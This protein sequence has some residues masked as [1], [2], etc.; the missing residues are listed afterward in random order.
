M[1]LIRII[2]IAAAAALGLAA[3]TAMAQG[4]YGSLSHFSWEV[5]QSNAPAIE[6]SGIRAVG[7][8]MFSDIFG[9]EGHV[10]SGGDDEIELGGEE[11]EAELNKVLGLFAKA[12]LPLNLLGVDLDIF[13]LVGYGYG[14]VDILAETT[15]TRVTE[16]SFAWGAGADVA[17][18]PE[19]LYLTADYVEYVNRTGIDANAA[20]L[21][22]RL[23]F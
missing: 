23:S 15:T 3:N 14:R 21:G 2:N 6:S 9:V 13:G 16:N 8:Y 22:L 4:G 19:R 17:L 12:N 7:G 18:I 11:A 5:D 10:A 1:K 20:S